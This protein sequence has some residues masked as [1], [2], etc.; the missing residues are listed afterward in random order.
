MTCNESNE[1]GGRQGEGRLA[2]GEE[3]RERCNTGLARNSRT[4]SFETLAQCET[5]GG[6]AHPA[7]RKGSF[8][9][10][11]L[12]ERKRVLAKRAILAATR[13][14]FNELR[15]SEAFVL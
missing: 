13:C 12:E 8:T 14:P 4:S 7:G 5:R 6:G 1:G 9:S 2:R 15:A 11:S 3:A 10:V